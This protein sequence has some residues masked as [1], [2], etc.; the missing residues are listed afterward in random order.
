MM[1]VDLG[2]RTTKAVHLRRANGKLVLCGYAITDSL[3]AAKSVSAESLSDH[4]KSLTEKLRPKTKSLT[5][6]VGANDAVLRTAEAPLMSKEDFRAVL[7]HNSKVYLQQEL[8]GYVFDVHPLLYFGKAESERGPQASVKKQ[9]Q[10]LLIAGAKGRLLDGYVEAAKGA[11]L[12]TEHVVPGLIGTINAFELAKP[13][14]FLGSAVALVDIGFK[15]S[16]ICVLN[17]GDLALSRVVAI[18][19][20]RITES[21]SE[22][23]N[24]G[25]AEAEGIKIGMSGDVRRELETVVGPL[26]RELRASIDFFEHEHDR[27]VSHVFICG[28]SARSDVVRQILES[29]L[30]MECSNWDPV[31]ILA[32][33]LSPQQD[34]EL[35]H[36]GAQFAVAVGA[37]LGAM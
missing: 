37:A 31:S 24:I 7:K 12:I 28:G 14:H 35:E 18:G 21:L 1:S 2:S 3:A 8:P 13:E 23:M 29:E 4:L 25:Y 20:D 27:T 10:R 22:I 33:E 36:V 32:K 15:T 26:G 17:R 30:M 19:G 6:T 34:A 9:K 16:S 5:L 11:G